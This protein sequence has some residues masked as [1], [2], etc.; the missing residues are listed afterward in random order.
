MSIILPDGWPHSVRHYP[1]Y[2]FDP[3]VVWLKSH[4]GAKGVHWDRS[5]GYWLFAHK[6][7][8]VL[9]AVTWL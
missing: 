9:F 8:A 4:V 2:N 1:I 6:S 5:A 3:Y 7:D